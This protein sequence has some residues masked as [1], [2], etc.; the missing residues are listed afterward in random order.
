MTDQPEAWR[1]DPRERLLAAIDNTWAYGTLGATPEDLVD[2]YAR[3]AVERYEAAHGPV[4]A[5][6]ATTG[7][8][9]AAEFKPTAAGL[10]SDAANAS[11]RELSDNQLREQYAAAIREWVSAEHADVHNAS[12]AI[13]AVRDRRLEQ[14]TAKVAD[15][16]N[17]INWHTTCGSCARVLDSA[18][19]DTARADQA[20]RESRE[21]QWRAGDAERRVRC[22]RQRAEQAEATLARVADLAA[23]HPVTVDTALL[24]ATLGQ[25]PASER[26]ATPAETAVR[27]AENLRDK[28]L[29]YPI[30]DMHHGAGLMLALYLAGEAF[31][32]VDPNEADEPACTARL[33]P[34]HCTQAA[35]HY[36]P[37]QHPDP[38]DPDDI[39]GWHAGPTGPPEHRDHRTLWR[40]Q[41]P[42]AT[43]HKEQL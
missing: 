17:R 26:R 7:D 43:P 24:H 34:V 33:G 2:D 21:S 14:L 4:D 41:D 10:K 13:L 30:G 23:E 3:R 19:R 18:Y 36:Q 39:G 32:S 27:R 8:T 16:E 5:A 42:D 15:Y 11:G 9:P 6:A 20:E 37:D 38:G 22:Q 28:W 12:G 40:D 35:G 1:T 31:G 29:A 25:P